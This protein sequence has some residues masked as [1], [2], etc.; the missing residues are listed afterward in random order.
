[1]D[2]LLYSYYRQRNLTKK[3]ARESLF[4]GSLGSNIRNLIQKDN[5][6]TISLI[7]QKIESIY[8]NDILFYLDDSLINCFMG[9]NL[10]DKNLL[11]ILKY[12]LSSINS[13]DSIDSL[14]FYDTVKLLLRLSYSKRVRIVKTLNKKYSNLDSFTKMLNNVLT[15]RKEKLDFHIDIDE[16]TSLFLDFLKIDEEDKVAL[17]WRY[18]DTNESLLDLLCDDNII[19]IKDNLKKMRNYIFETKLKECFGFD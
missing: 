2:L 8:K 6:E 19:S 12:V 18:I 13:I 4:I 7:K 11:Y 5:E 3:I 10:S 1:M 15:H 17:E 14:K 16:K 9:E